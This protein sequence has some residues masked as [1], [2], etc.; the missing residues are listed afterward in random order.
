[1]LQ[2]DKG[3]GEL[4]LIFIVNLISQFLRN[5]FY[6]KYPI[7]CLAYLNTPINES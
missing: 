5:C 2:T 4:M 7:Q 1:M 3:N 6:Q